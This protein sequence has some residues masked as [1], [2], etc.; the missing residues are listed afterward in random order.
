MMMMTRFKE[1]H[2]DRQGALSNVS[3]RLRY[4]GC[5]ILQSFL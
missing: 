3:K 2:F 5:M 1:R 4:D